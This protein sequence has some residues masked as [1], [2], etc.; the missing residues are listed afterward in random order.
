MFRFLIRKE[1][2]IVEDIIVKYIGNVGVPALLCFYCMF[3][4]NKSLQKLTDAITELKGNSEILTRLDT[5]DR[6]F[7]KAIEKIDKKISRIAIAVNMSRSRKGV[8]YDEDIED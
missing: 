6:E 8:D 3:N 4:V 2:K 7:S 1:S 5:N